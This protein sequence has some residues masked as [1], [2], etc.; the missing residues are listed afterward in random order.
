MQS[1]LQKK[2]SKNRIC[3]DGPILIFVLLLTGFTYCAQELTIT[4][5]ITSGED[6]SA[7]P[8]A[9]I[10]IKG[11]QNGTITDA[12]GNFSLQ[13]QKAD[14]VLVISFVG[15]ETQEVAVNGRNIIDVALPTD[16]TQLSEIVVTALG[17]EKDKKG[18]GYTTQ[19]V[20]GSQLIQ[21]RE[22]NLVSSLAGRVAG[23]NIVNNPSGIGSSSRITIRGERSLN[24]NNNQPLFVVDG[25]PISNSFSGSS[26]GPGGRNQDVDFGNGAGFINPDDVE[27]MTVLK[28]GSAAALYGARAK[29][30]V[31]I[32][33]TKHEMIQMSNQS[34]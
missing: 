8:G 31:I 19:S 1:F 10:L 32:I 29:N 22:T 16:A 11:T 23:V 14:A 13:Q 28:G 21:A 7:I 34:K 20:E 30:G 18:L 2:R 5:K 25:V 4:V 6:Q 26:G 33:K 9:N 15:F 24:I 27:S 12:E 17:I 3:L